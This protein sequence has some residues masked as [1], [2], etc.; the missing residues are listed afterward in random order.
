MRIGIGYD[1]HRL[2]ENRKLIIGGVT[3]DY[4]LGL[5]GHSDADVLTHAIMDA[6]LGALSLGDIGK[7]FPDTDPKYKDIDSLKLLDKVVKLMNENGYRIGNVDSVVICEEPKINPKREE[8][9]KILAYHLQTD[10]S[11]V[12]V[13]ASTS[14][15]LSFTGKGLGIEARSV[16]ILEEKN[17]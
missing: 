16:V 6:I 4:K 9:R 3:F 7:L 15:G 13:K 1:V 2:V 17:A 12:S 10:I 5:L 14:E 8:I 11:N